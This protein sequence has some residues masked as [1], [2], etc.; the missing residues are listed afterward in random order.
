MVPGPVAAASSEN[1]LELQIF[2][3]APNL[4]ELE[5][6]GVRP[7]CLMFLLFLSANLPVISD[8]Q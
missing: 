5:I 2:G 6:Q 4:L 8:T 1:L 3:P 7:S